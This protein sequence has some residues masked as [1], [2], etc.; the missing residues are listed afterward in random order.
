M[1]VEVDVEEGDEMG[2]FHV[3]YAILELGWSLSWS[4]FIQLPHVIV[5]SCYI[6]HAIAVAIA[7]TIAAALVV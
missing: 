6:R 3:L 5:N 4:R 1:V 2:W 7:V